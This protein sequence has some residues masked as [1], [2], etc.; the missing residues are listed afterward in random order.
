MGGEGGFL[1]LC[2]PRAVRPAPKANTSSAPR[3][4][5]K[6]QGKRKPSTLAGAVEGF[7]GCVK[8]LVGS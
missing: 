4:P 7:A 8:S 5:R 6:Y 3:A 1:C 2:G